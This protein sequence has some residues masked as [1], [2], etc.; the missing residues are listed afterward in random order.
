MSSSIEAPEQANSATA[1]AP[2]VAAPNEPL[3]VPP[4][5]PRKPASAAQLAALQRGRENLRL[6]RQAKKAQVDSVSADT[7]GASASVEDKPRK[8]RARTNPV[9]MTNGEIPKR[10]GLYLSLITR[11]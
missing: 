2:P 6:A 3:P 5:K 4:R 10:F 9:V 7:Q 1:P 8:K 11:S